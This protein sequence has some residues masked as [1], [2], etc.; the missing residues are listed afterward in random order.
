M[1]G[2]RFAVL[3]WA[4]C[5]AIA[6]PTAV[7]LAVG[8]D[9]ALPSDIFSGIGGV[10]FLVL[11]L[12]FASVG[13]IVAARVPENS[14]GWIFCL[15]GL[16]TA[17]QVLTWQYADVGL[18]TA[19]D[20][21]GTDAAAVFNTVIG[22]QTAGWLGLTLLL[23]PDGRLPSPHWRPALAINLSGM[24]LLVA[25]G[26]FRPGEYNEPFAAV[27]NPFGIAGARSTMNAVDIAGWLLVAAAI[28]LGAAALVVRLRRAQGVERQQLELVL[29]VGSAAA[30]AATLLMATWLIWPEGHLQARIAVLGFC[31]ATFPVAAG[32]AIL[33]YRLYEIDVVVNRTLVYVALTAV[34][35]VAFATSVL[36]LGT[37]L[38]RGSPLATAGATLVVA[39]L[40]RPL[41]ARVQ[42]AVDRRFNRARYDALHRMTDFLE[43][44]RAG[45][46]A[47]EHVEPLLRELLA[48]P[49]LELLFVLPDSDGHV[50]ARG[51]AAV[52]VPNDDR[53]RVPIVRAGQPLGIVLHTPSGEEQ[54]LLLQRVVEA[55]G[56]AIEIARLR[57]ELR[58][59]L[60][61]VEASRARIVTAANEERRR[62]ERDL[63]D[64]AQQRLVTIGLALRHAQ[65]ELDGASPERARDTLDGAVAEVAV[66]IDELRELAHGLPPSQLDAGLEP[67][68]C[69]LARRSPVP[70]EVDAARERFDRDIEAAAYFIGCEGLTNAVKHARATR[71][72]LSAGRRD[73]CLV[74]SVADDGVGG[75]APF[76]GSGLSG[77]ADRV[78][79]LGGTIR[80]ESVCGAGTTLT[81]ELPCGS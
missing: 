54:E 15:T 2:R 31:F 46:A 65:H 79:A 38:G 28:A 45:R 68:F 51:A 27:T 29:A 53:E 71:I 30:T 12:T 3:A 23:F 17:L 16:L 58:R 43:D 37:A 47:P 69:E 77:V 78:A 55:G 10:A 34:L 41:R 50:D 4:L 7:L 5:A 61:E 60:A 70:I 49:R 42:D 57:V 18:H 8:P 63:H 44:L 39:L 73:G 19:H 59:Q 22:E 56:L 72:T 52:E 67:A 11:A 25:A 9:R 6:V 14:I 21:P 75:A 40:F 33:R 35:A 74:V 36:L 26:T 32:V 81:A 13:A 24:A 1:I 48:D 64:G 62:I 80:L 20:L 76:A 66:A